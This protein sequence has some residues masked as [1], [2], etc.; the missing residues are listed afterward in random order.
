MALRTHYQHRAFSHALRTQRCSG[1]AALPRGTGTQPGA[2][3]TLPHCTL[4]A[5]H[6]RHPRHARFCLLRAALR[7]RALKR[8]I[9]ASASV[10]ASPL[11]DG[12]RDI[13]YHT[14]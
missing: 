7:R 3:R 13:F 10:A 14:R 6:L 4:L 5:Q 1:A 12:S 9:A 11:M 2:P 8:G